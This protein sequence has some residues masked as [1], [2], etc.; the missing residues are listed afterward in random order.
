[1]QAADYK[2]WK[3]SVDSDQIAWLLIDRDG[4]STNT[5]SQDV[6]AEF[7][8]ILDKLTT[9][10]P[11]GLV[12]MS[13]KK[14]GFIAGA[15]I[16]EFEDFS[17]AAE[18]TGLVNQ[19]H[20][21]FAKLEKLK[22]PTVAAV[23][24]FCVGGGYELALCC[25]YIMALDVPE[26]RVGLPEIKLGIM[27]GLGG[28]VRLNERV[29]SMKGMTAMLTGKLYRVR[30][31]KALGMIDEVVSRHSNL[32]WAARRAVLQKRKFKGPSLVARAVNSNL[33]R[34]TLAG[35]MVKQTSAKAS[36][37]HY[38]APFA[39]IDMWKEQ[40]GD[41]AAKF[42]AEAELFGKL[43]VSS[44]SRGLQRVFHL[45]ER[46]KKQG[47]KEDFTCRRVHVIGAG[48][49]GGDIAAW[50]ALQGMEVTVQDR[51]MK[52]IEPAIDRARKLFKRKTRS[53]HAADAAAARF[54]PDVDGKG[55]ARADVIIEAI[56]E[57]VEA[58]QALYKSI[59]PN[60]KDDAVLATNTS[61]IPLETLS[62]VL[63]NP[64]RL[65]GLHFF[66]PV[67]KMPLVEVVHAAD[68][69]Q[70]MVDRGSAFCGQINRFPVVV[71]S[72]PGF[73]VNRVLAPYMLEAMK[74]F[75]E[76]MSKEA[77]DA[78]AVKFGMPMG[79]IELA[80]TVGLDVGLSVVKNLGGEGADVA[81]ERLGK[82]V[83]AGELGKK[84]G[85]GFYQWIKG[86]PQ[87][88]EYEADAKIDERAERLLKPFLD[89]CK[90]CSDDGIVADDDLLDA[91]IIFGTGFAPFTGGPM[92]YLKT[93]D[94][95]AASGS[96]TA[97]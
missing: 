83:E 15:D 44:E 87:K 55:V 52:Y 48:V 57:N 72:S 60:M 13:G 21:V 67:A 11:R 49:M 25:K 61:A 30:Q 9:D 89:E 90:A 18:V 6:I 40:K 95:N 91:G 76:G 94:A 56:F 43:L 59:E 35:Q 36:P 27:P 80:D 28:T 71:K 2:H 42:T 69:D 64:S 53:K 29:G 81:V 78:A 37:D 63:A 77:I 50:C 93:R 66:N 16:R 68:T 92:H 20:A 96:A 34:D 31:A 74:M 4:E 3:L 62:T 86:K 70:K 24:G 75:D 33:A 79:P 82:M 97:E 47:K 10:T 38:P 65:V 23:A 45:M 58:K 46:L 51:E 54:L 41:R 88:E 1:M 85:S 14:G 12:I 7:D 39:L 19:G 8:S 5:L 32:R 17:N 26:T 84:S 73:L 22:C